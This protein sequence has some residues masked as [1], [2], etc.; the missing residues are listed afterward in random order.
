MWHLKRLPFKNGRTIRFHCNQNSFLHL[1]AIKMIYSLTSWLRSSALVAITSKSIN[2]MKHSDLDPSLSLF[3]SGI[4]SSMDTDQCQGLIKLL[5]KSSFIGNSEGLKEI[6]YHFFWHK[7]SVRILWVFCIIN[8]SQYIFCTFHSKC[9]QH[10]LGLFL[11]V[12]EF[13]ILV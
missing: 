11:E 4:Y 10:N 3:G 6:Y 8:S 12:G 7:E 13:Q 2:L 1:R 5:L 9:E